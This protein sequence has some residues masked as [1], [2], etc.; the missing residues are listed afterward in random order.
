MQSGG[1]AAVPLLLVA[2]VL[3][4][5]WN[6]LAFTAV[7]ELAGPG[8]AGTALGLQNTAVA[9]G[10]ALT[11]PVLGA[12]VDR[13]S[14]GVGYAVAAAAALAAVMLLGPL[15][16]AERPGPAVPADASVA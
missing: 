6:G 7:G 4:I 10:A 11:A 14:W 5:S 3:A 8:R 2:G 15:V 12:V 13:T 16:R 1:R 9:L